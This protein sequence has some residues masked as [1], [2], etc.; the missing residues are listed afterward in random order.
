MGI[1]ETLNKN[2]AITT[3]VT[4]GIIALA[5]LII[6]Y[7]LIFSGGG[8]ASI[9]YDRGFYSI[10]DGASTFE[11]DIMLV[12]P[13][14]KD[15]KEAVRAYVYTCDGGKTKFVAY[16]ERYTAKGKKAIE[17]MRKK[18]EEAAKNNAPPSPEIFAM[19][20]MQFT[21]REVKKPG[22]G[23]WV[24]ASSPEAQTVMQVTCPEG[25]STDTL[26]PVMP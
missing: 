12:A 9:T 7:Q 15:G 23:K 13:F 8:G 6:L 21:E 26:E 24:R 16:L 18:Q 20:Q 14:Q 11:D 19:E 4:G 3:G 2:P 22:T 25:Q 10:D 17:D 5:I 1:R